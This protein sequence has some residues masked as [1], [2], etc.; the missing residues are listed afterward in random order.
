MKI[1]REGMK[2]VLDFI[3]MSV[4][5]EKPFFVWYA[6]FL[7]HTPHNPPQRLL[8]TAIILH[9]VYDSYDLAALALAA[10][11]EMTGDGVYGDYLKGLKKN[12]PLVHSFMN[13][14]NRV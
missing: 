13:V 4:E 1:G 2:P 14:R 11:E 9:E 12:Q 10:R 8:K 3:D 7:P 5:E 6:P